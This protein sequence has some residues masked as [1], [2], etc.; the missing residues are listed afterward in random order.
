MRVIRYLLSNPMS[1][2]GLL[3]LL[4]FVLIAVF[5]PVLAPPQEFQLSPYDTP[6]AG[7]WATPQPPSD[8]AL[9]GTCLLYTSR[10]AQGLP[11]RAVLLLAAGRGG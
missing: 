3:L 11:A 2:F 5:A 4:A 10:P 9:F 6:R 8:L 1:L 7:F